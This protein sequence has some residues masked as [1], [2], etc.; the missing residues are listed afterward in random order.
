MK[1]KEIYYKYREPLDFTNNLI[2]ICKNFVAFILILQLALD[3]STVDNLVLW[4]NDLSVVIKIILAFTAASTLIYGFY[5]IYQSAKYYHALSSYRTGLEDQATTSVKL[6]GN[7][8]KIIPS[9]TIVR[10]IY[11]EFN[12]RAKQWSP[13]CY[14]YELELKV[15]YK[16]QEITS[17]LEATFFSP[18]KSASLIQE[19]NDRL[20]IPSNR[21]P[22]P[23]QI[24]SHRHHLVGGAPFFKNKSWR[25]FTIDC[26]EKI[27]KDIAGH[28]FYLTVSSWIGG[29]V[30]FYLDPYFTPKK[31]F[32]FHLHKN[33][34]S[35]EE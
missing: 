25:R 10:E 33:G 3:S 5:K 31:N 9:T 4:M 13:D 15:W 17:Q 8:K 24:S 16:P 30:R 2:Q 12:R 23:S 1:V 7:Y 29:E 19:T 20:K 32:T 28:Q 18:K 11:S 34:L 26:L 6:I 22:I 35:T 27:E 14:L 21:E